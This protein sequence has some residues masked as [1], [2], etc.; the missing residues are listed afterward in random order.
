MLDNHPAPVF[1]LLRGAAQILSVHGDRRVRAAML[2]GPLAN[3]VVQGLWRQGG[4]EGGDRG[5]G[6]ALFGRAP[7]RTHRLELLLG[8]QG[9]E[10]GERVDP[11]SRAATAITRMVLSA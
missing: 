5:R 10:L 3:R 2:A 6:V 1:G 7:E 11:A 8:E 4:V 9:G